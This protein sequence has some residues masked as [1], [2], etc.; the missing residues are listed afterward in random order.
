V[1]YETHG[2]MQRR[3]WG[4]ARE[5]GRPHTCCRRSAGMPS[6]V[7][8]LSGLRVAGGRRGGGRRPDTGC[9]RVQDRCCGT[10]GVRLV[11]FGSDFVILGFYVGVFFSAVVRMLMADKLHGTTQAQRTAACRQIF[12]IHPEIW[13]KGKEKLWKE[14]ETQSS[15]H[16]M[17][18]STDPFI[19]V[20]GAGGPIPVAGRRR[21]GTA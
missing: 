12:Q 5:R 4:G 2:V 14:S 1:I 16:Q 9:V 6:A 17:E 8:A 20:R 3:R 19:A 13:A 11:R 18:K 10:E 7:A 21:R 15:T